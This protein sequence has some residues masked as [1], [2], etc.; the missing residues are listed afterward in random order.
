[1]SYLH[2]R[3]NARDEIQL[4]VMAIEKN[5]SSDFY[6]LASTSLTSNSDISFI[7]RKSFTFP[8]TLNRDDEE[9]IPFEETIATVRFPGK[10]ST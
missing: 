6:I 9:E 4:Y 10:V 3:F 2:I 1:M 8:I 7:F 5:E